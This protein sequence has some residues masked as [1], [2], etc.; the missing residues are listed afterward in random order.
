VNRLAISFSGGRT[1]GLMLRRLLDTVRDTEVVTMFANTSQEDDRTLEFVD[2]VDREWGAKVVWLEAIVHDGHGEGTTHRVVDFATANR[3]GDVFESAIAKYGIPNK[4]FP[5]SCTRELKLRPTTSYLRSIGWGPGTYDTAIGIRADE[6]DR[7]DSMA[8][9][10]RFIYPLAKSGITK[11][12]VLAFWSAQPFD[13]QVPEHLGNCTWC[14]K[15][16][17][18]KHLTIAIERPE[19]FDFPR[20]M[21]A[22]Y[23]N[24]GAGEGVRTFFRSH[25]TV[26]DIFDKAT[27]PF[28]RFTENRVVQLPLGLMDV[29]DGCSESCEI[30]V[31]GSDH[32]EAA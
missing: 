13:L 28:E 6:M 25:M 22:K 17:L 16:S 21:E 14:W 1:S 4:S 3:A 7:M 8:E 29:P 27:A 31:D 24:A 9:K 26:Q 12:D 20:R 10:K 2:R 5:G 32:S 11:Q 19:A 23:A 15:K 18:R 30:Y